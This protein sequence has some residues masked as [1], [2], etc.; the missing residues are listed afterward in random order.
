MGAPRAW[1]TP[2]WNGEVL[3]GQ[4]L[5]IWAE[6][7]LGDTLQFARYARLLARAGADVVLEVQPSLERLVRE[8]L[9]DVEVIAY[10]Q[11]IPDH[12]AQV[13]LLSLPLI[14]GTRLGSIPADVPYLSA[15][16]ERVRAWAERLG[17][18]GGMRRVGLVWAGNREHKNDRRRS[19]EPDLLR[20]LA[21]LP[22]I[23]WLR[24]QPGATPRPPLEMVD[25][26]AELADFADTAALLM[27]L[28]LVITVDTSVAHLAG[29]LGRPV[30][31]MLPYE[32]DWRW[33]LER[34]ESPWY[35]TARLFR[36]ARPGDWSS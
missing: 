9:P 10:G 30:W 3:P 26:T 1:S 36:Q 16:P 29:A 13:P 8:S 6:Q 19:L 22:S 14:L 33:L 12:D 17:P 5:L 15:D 23:E 28:D 31:I 25:R 35:P 27:Q 7:G 11:S 2:R 32:P 20:P 21:E 34:T 4:R 18:P 24:V